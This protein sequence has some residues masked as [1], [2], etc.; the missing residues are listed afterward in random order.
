MEPLIAIRG[1]KK[2]FRVRGRRV[3][4]LQGIDVTVRAGEVFGMLG[5]NGSGKSTALRLLMGLTRADAGTC[6]LFGAPAVGRAHLRR[7]GYLPERLSFFEHSTGAE[8][9]RL[10]ARL[11][12]LSTPETVDAVE[13]TAALTGIA[14]Y[15]NRPV[16][17]YSKG[18]R[19]RLGWAQALL[20][21]P[22]LLI[23]DEPTTGLDPLAKE[24]FHGL[25]GEWKAAGKTVVLCTHELDEAER[26]CGRVTI[27]FE[28]RALAEGGPRG[29]GGA[30]GSG[31]AVFRFRGLGPA[32]SERLVRW[33]AGEGI[34]WERMA[35]GGLRA[36]VLEKLRWA[37]RGGDE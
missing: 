14:D 18:M 27:L 34:E 35:T 22:E 1:L 33:L 12:G 25:V 11:G 26:L 37:R 17:T 4:A 21:D 2:S 31:E 5:P 9:L 20:H 36:S 6:M 30:D 16:R 28:G 24:A 8:N 29:P 13:Q 15:A 3:A 7:V 32:E 23:F 10:L 19:Q